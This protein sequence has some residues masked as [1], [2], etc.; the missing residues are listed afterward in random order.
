M[1]HVD[2]ADDLLVL[3]PDGGDD[4]GDIL[5]EALAQRGERGVIVGVLL[6]DLGDVDQ[7]GESILFAIFP[8]L[9]RADADA[10]L[11]RA[12]DDGGIGSLTGLRS[13][14]GKVE[15][16][17]H[18]EHVDLAAVIFH[19]SHCQRNGDLAADLFGIVVA[20]GVAVGNLTQT[21]RAAGQKQH[22]FSEGG[23]AAAAVAKQ[24]DIANVFCTHNGLV[25]FRKS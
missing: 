25:S 12:D 3:V 2:D 24:H 7:T 23:L 11:G 19:G 20:N 22:S 13:L 21:V 10:G 1:Q 6:I 5:A 14:A 4:G 9:L 8:R 15:T 17:G 16:A 18:V